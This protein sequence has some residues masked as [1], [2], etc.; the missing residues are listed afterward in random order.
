[1]ILIQL[2]E[3]MSRL[4]NEREQIVDVLKELGDEIRRIKT[5]IE[6]GDAVSKTETGKLMADLRYWMR[7]SHETE[8]QIANVRRK[9]KGLVGDWALDLERARDEIGCR[10]ARLRRCCGAGELPR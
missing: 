1:M 4:E 6:D 7:A 8:A 10:M 9:Q 5:Q 3:E 2:E